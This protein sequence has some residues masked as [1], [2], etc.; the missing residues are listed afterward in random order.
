LFG[1][2]LRLGKGF[3]S[4]HESIIAFKGWGMNIE[5]G[6]IQGKPRQGMSGQAMIHSKDG[7]PFL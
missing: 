4:C 5:I 1:S 6:S 7:L 2:R 3:G